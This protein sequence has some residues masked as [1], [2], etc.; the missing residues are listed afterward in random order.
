M[1]HT[2]EGDSPENLLSYIGTTCVAG[3]RKVPAAVARAKTE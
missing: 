3:Q 1:T 2:L